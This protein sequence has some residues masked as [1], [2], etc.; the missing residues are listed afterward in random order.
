MMRIKHIVSGIQQTLNTC[1]MTGKNFVEKQNLS[2]MTV[3]CHSQY[4]GKHLLKLQKNEDV[5]AL[6]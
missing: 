2:T 3:T 6:P 5:W 1:L 4:T